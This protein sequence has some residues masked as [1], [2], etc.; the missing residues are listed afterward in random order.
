MKKTKQTS[1]HEYINLLW[2]RYSKRIKKKKADA[3]FGTQYEMYQMDICMVVLE[4]L[5]FADDKSESSSICTRSKFDFIIF[6][7]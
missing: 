2:Y 5:H 6:I 4:R 1:E 7:Y 3:A